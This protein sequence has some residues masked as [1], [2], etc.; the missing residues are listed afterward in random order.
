[1]KTVGVACLVLV[2]LLTAVS[3]GGDDAQ[4]TTGAEAVAFLRETER[5][6]IAALVANDIETARGLHA[7]DFRL[8]APDG[9]ELTK[10][11]Y[12]DAVGSGRLDYVLWEPK[13]PLRVQIDGDNA[14]IRY[15]SEIGFAGTGG[16][17][18]EQNH[19][20]TYELRDGNW[21]IVRSVT[22]FGPP[23]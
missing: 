5:Q 15:R 1:M 18:T 4:P 22:A 13:S 3:C 16:G 8:S 11:E 7:D 20:D 21:Q 2:F 23:E 10:D 9:D 6:R 14:V 19:T 17:T 12:L